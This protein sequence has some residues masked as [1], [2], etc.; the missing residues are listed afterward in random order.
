MYS[1]ILALVI[2]TLKT[3]GIEPEQAKIGEGQFNINK[4][5]NTEVLIDVWEENNRIFFQVLSPV[6]KINDVGR[7]EVLKMLLEENHGLVEAS[8]ALANDDII[9]KDTIECSAFFNQERALSTITRIAFY[10]EL[11]KER[12]NK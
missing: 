11:Y 1:Q 5:K 12:W 10:C 4:D 7:A 2:N 6:T 3:L 8:F 9:L